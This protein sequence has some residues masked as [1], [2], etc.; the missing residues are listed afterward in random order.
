VVYAEFFTEPRPTRTTVAAELRDVK[1][2][3]DA[4]FSARE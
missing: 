3:M 4:I 1:V 2:E